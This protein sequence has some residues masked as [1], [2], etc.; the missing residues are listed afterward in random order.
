MFDVTLYLRH[1]GRASMFQH[2]GMIVVSAHAIP[3]ART[4]IQDCPICSAS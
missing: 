2:M 3:F 4:V 1:V